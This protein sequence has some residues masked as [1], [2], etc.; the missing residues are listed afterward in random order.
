MIKKDHPLQTSMTSLKGLFLFA[1][2]HVHLSQPICFLLLSTLSLVHV[3]VLKNWQKLALP[4]IA[5]VERKP[6]SIFRPLPLQQA[7]KSVRDSVRVAF[8]PM[9]MQMHKE[10]SIFYPRPKPM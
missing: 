5:D 6:H 2:N 7:W 8:W 4:D 1:C 3:C 10:Q 9:P